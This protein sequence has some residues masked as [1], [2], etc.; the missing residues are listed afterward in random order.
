LKK[1][2]LGLM[3]VVLAVS[4]VFIG[5]NNKATPTTTSKATTS[6]A[7]TTLT[8]VKTGG[9]L[10]FI[11]N[12]VPQGS[13][14]VGNNVRGITIFSI[15]PNETLLIPVIDGSFLPKLAASYEW[16]NNNKT[17]TFHL[18]Q[19]VKFHDGTEFNADAVKWNWDLAVAAKASGT[20][21]IISTEIVDKYTFRVNIKAYDNLWLRYLAG[22]QLMISPTAY[23][24][25]GADY[26]DWHPVGTGPFKFVSYKENEEMNF[27][28]FDDYWGQKANIDALKILLIPDKVTAQI[29]LEAKQGDYLWVLGGGAEL[30]HSLAGKNLTLEAGPGMVKVLVP[31]SANPD[32]PFNKQKV[33]EAI[34]YAIDKSKICENIGFN[35]WEPRYMD[36]GSPQGPYI[37]NYVGRTYN[38]EK[39]KQLL[40]EAGYPNGFKTKLWE[41]AVFAGDEL[42]AIQAYFKAV[43]IEAEIEIV[44]PPKWVDYET[45]GLPEGLEISPHSCLYY[46]FTLSRFYSKAPQPPGEV[47]YNNTVYFP[48]GL[49]K[50]VDEYL[51]IPDTDFNQLVKKGQEVAK[52]IS[53]YAIEIPLWELPEIFV[54]QPYCRDVGGDKYAKII[55]PGN[56]GFNEA[57]LDK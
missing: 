55:Y 43:G 36:V 4:L 47:K 32:S 2:L 8:K 26:M 18:R 20:D 7:T 57:W 11:V 54:A 34:E 29:A 37:P 38:P 25:N 5:C 50:M 52:Y 28:R 41:C 1:I 13:I 46:G 51:A 40:T 9:T 19:G 10:T 35:Y 33:R 24:K 53:D 14:G 48:D 31:S 3:M 49:Q 15:I 17:V 21:N 23:Q 12:E 6:A 27:V 22:M 16:S 56:F 44:T 39:A 42:P 45:N 30:A